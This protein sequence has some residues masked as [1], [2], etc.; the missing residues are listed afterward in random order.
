MSPVNVSVRL[1]NWVGDVCMALPALQLL[2][3]SGCQLQ[4]LGRGWARDLLAGFDGEVRVIPHGFR[5]A[6]RAWRRAGASDGILFTNSVSSAL[7][8]RAGGVSTIG[9]ARAGR[10]YL[11]SRSLPRPLGRYH[12]V[13]SLF[14]LALAFCRQYRLPVA[15]QVPGSRLHL[16]LHPFHRRLADQILDSA[17]LG[18]FFI[19]VAPLASGKIRGRSKAWPGFFDL[20]KRLLAEGHRLVM[21]PGPGEEAEAME[22]V[23]GATS[24]NGLSLGVYSSICARAQLVVANDSGPSHLA[25]AVN[26]PTLAIFGLGEPWRTSPWGGTW[27]GSSSGWPDVAEVQAACDTLLTRRALDGAAPHRGGAREAA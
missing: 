5:N 14:A 17:G 2:R 19:V 25:A 16:P 26:A 15:R 4:L 10:R 24:L 12:E 23:P 21:C 18:P 13:E 3:E 7:Q 6:A 1:P 8:A 22:V 27:V 20:G 9:Y 11:L